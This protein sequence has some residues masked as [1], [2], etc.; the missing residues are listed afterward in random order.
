MAMCP[1]CELESAMLHRGKCMDGL[2]CLDRLRRL[3]RREYLF[4]PKVKLTQAEEAEKAAFEAEQKIEEARR[5]KVLERRRIPELEARFKKQMKASKLQSIRE[6]QA[7]IDS[8]VRAR[9]GMHS[10]AWASGMKEAMIRKFISAGC[11]LLQAKRTLRPLGISGLYIRAIYAQAAREQW[12]RSHQ[13]SERILPIGYYGDRDCG[14]VNGCAARPD[15]AGRR[16]ETLERKREYERQR[17]ARN[18]ES[19][20]ARKRE[21]WAQR[22]G[23]RA[24][25]ITRDDSIKG[26]PV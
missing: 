10:G 5:L 18:G 3:A 15:Y 21:W 6:R 24:A 11:S 17:R 20:N 8:I 7:F 1:M 25:G 4:K 9:R 12:E 22:G 26:N 16:A 14:C 19:I 2:A 23:D 13:F